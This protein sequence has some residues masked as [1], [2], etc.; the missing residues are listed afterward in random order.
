M[1][2][3]TNGMSEKENRDKGSKDGAA[4][5]DLQALHFVQLWLFEIAS[6]RN[7]KQF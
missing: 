3:V 5:R 2:S 1:V 7:T 6:V 4:R